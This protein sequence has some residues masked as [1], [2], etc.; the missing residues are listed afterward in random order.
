MKLKV[1]IREGEDG[2]LVVQ[3]PSIPGCISQGKNLQEALD[4]IKEAIEGCIEVMDERI[5][6]T[7]DKQ[8]M[9]VWQY[10]ETNFL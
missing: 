1:L 2:W 8:M 10:S 3:C 4:N 5:K 7:G 9:E 6:A